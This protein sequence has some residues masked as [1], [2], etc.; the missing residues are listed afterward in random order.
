MKHALLI[1]RKAKN[2]ATT[3]QSRHTATKWRKEREKQ[4]LV[5]LSVKAPTESFELRSREVTWP[6][7]ALTCPSPHTRKTALHFLW[8]PEE[9]GFPYHH[10]RP[11]FETALIA[12]GLAAR[13][14]SSLRQVPQGLG[15]PGTASLGEA[16][17]ILV[18]PP[19]TPCCCTGSS[20]GI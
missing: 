12:A 15:A 20:S 8:S 16:S 19:P 7:A 6:P 14:E 1:E 10:H 17:L 2:A 3:A 5:S 11:A 9:Q 18:G 4:Q 13:L